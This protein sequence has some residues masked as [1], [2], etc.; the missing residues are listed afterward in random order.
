M[1]TKLT[2]EQ[3]AKIPEYEA[4]FRRRGTCTRPTDRV[5]AEKT[6]SQLFTYLKKPQP[7]VLWAEDPI[8]GCIL[9]AKAKKAASP[10]D[11]ADPSKI[12]VKRQDCIEELSSMSQPQAENYWISF[13]A[14]LAYELPT[15][16]DNLIDIAVDLGKEISAYWI[17]EEGFVVAVPKPVEMHF[18]PEGVLENKKGPAL[19]YASGYSV[20]KIGDRR[21]KSLLEATIAGALE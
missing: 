1:I 18:T 11:M 7:I 6:F 2:P 15:K 19:R 5:A 21:F 17:F 10:A 9:A 13:Y 12:K 20:Y 4:E 8:Q 16:H 14:F 3:E